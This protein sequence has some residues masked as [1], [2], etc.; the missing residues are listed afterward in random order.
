M[1]TIVFKA[2]GAAE[3]TLKPAKCHL[4]EQKVDYLGHVVLPG[5]LQVAQKKVALLKECKYPTNRS[6]MRTFFRLCNIYRR[7]FPKFARVAHP[8]NQ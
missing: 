3:V 4:F 8:L 7:F 2:L 1:S 5:K 6:E